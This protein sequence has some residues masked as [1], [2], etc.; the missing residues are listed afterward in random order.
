MG[1]EISFLRV[2]DWSDYFV[3]FRRQPPLT[4]GPPLRQRRYGQGR[5][6][7]HFILATNGKGELYTY[8][9]AFLEVGKQKEPGYLTIEVDIQHALPV[10]V[11][12]R[13]AEYHKKKKNSRTTSRCR[14]LQ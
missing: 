7:K 1:T 9:S 5:L 11:I 10:D 3:F 12:S 14:Y 6:V 13:L 2:G 4:L 8:H